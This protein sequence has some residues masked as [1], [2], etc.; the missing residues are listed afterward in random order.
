MYLVPTKDLI[1]GDTYLMPSQEE[2]RYLRYNRRL[3]IHYFLNINT[4]KTFEVVDSMINTIT[5]LKKNKNGEK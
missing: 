5:F 4:G 3:R 1:L 2:V